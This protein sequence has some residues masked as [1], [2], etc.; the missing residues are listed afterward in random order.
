[1]GQHSEKDIGKEASQM[2]PLYHLCFFLG[3]LMALVG[4]CLVLPYVIEFF[5]EQV[6]DIT[7]KTNSALRY[8]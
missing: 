1:M 6:K 5:G 7:V 8:P 3:L 2:S 4:I